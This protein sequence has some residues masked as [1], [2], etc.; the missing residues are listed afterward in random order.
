M[1]ISQVIINSVPNVILAET[2]LKIFYPPHCDV[3]DLSYTVSNLMS[4]HSY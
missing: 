2:K 4:A 1:Q 3:F